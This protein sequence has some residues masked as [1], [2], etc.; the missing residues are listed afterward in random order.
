MVHGFDSRFID[1]HVARF[2]LFSI[3]FFGPSHD[4]N[5]CRPSA[6][7]SDVRVGPFYI[8]SILQ[9]EDD[10][11]GG[12]EKRLK[13]QLF[14]QRWELP[15]LSTSVMTASEATAGMAVTT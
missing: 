12:A 1:K 6:A 13:R 8:H 15:C 11:T 3:F 2:F 4:R 5:G 9:T 7:G 10:R 14:L